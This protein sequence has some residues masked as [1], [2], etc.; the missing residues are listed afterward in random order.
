MPPATLAELASRARLVPNLAAKSGAHIANTL[1]SMAYNTA[2]TGAPAWAGIPTSAGT[3]AAGVLLDRTATGALALPPDAEIPTTP[4]VF[5]SLNQ[6]TQVMT[7]CVLMDRVWHYQHGTSIPAGALTLASPP[8]IAS[9]LRNA[10]LVWAVEISVAMAAT[11]F[12]LTLT[13]EHEDLTTANVTVAIPA[14][15]SAQRVFGINSPDGKPIRR[16]TAASSSAANTGNLYITANVP[17][18]IIASHANRRSGAPAVL[19]PLT[20]GPIS[21]ARRNPCFVPWAFAENATAGGPISM[22]E[23]GDL[24]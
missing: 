18:P 14:S 23:I 24:T 4:A 5:R 10:G 7:L 12:N 8:D 15:A 22:L 21:W 9:A 3:V 2:L 6:F 1:G 19:D 11:A 13:L 17:G 20:I 16:V